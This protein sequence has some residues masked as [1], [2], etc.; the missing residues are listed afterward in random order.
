M[1]QWMDSNRNQ[2]LP[3][4]LSVLVNVPQNIS[5]FLRH[6]WKICSNFIFCPEATTGDERRQLP[7]GSG[8]LLGDLRFSRRTAVS[9][10]VVSIWWS[11]REI[12][13]LI[14]GLEP[15]RALV[16]QQDGCCS[17]FQ[18]FNLIKNQLIQRSFLNQVSD[19]YFCFIQPVESESSSDEAVSRWQRLRCWWGSRV[20]VFDPRL[21]HGDVSLSSAVHLKS[22]L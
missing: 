22:S 13:Y 21:L 9:P 6:F 12:G 20:E 2:S 15:R 1:N 4:W 19:M 3:G 10:L 18:C 16:Q 5:L 14:W 17:C 7:P 8:A 11:E